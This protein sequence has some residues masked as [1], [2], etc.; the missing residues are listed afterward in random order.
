MAS[1]PRTVQEIQATATMDPEFAS[2]YSGEAEFPWDISALKKIVMDSLLVQQAKL[3]NTKP[4]QIIEREA[5]IKLDD[6]TDIRTIVCHQKDI[7]APSPVVILFHGGGHCIGF[8]EME[9]PFARDVALR[10][11]A[12]VICPAP[13]LAPEHE[14][15]GPVDDAFAITKCVAQELQRHNPSSG[16]FLPKE[17]S[18]QA[19]FIIGGTSSGANLATVVAHLARDS[20]LTPPLTGQYIPAGNFVNPFDVPEKYRPYYLSFEQNAKAPVIW[21]EFLQ[22]ARDALKADVNSPLWAPF[23]QHSPKDKHGE[24]IE[25]HVGL[26]PAYFQV[27]GLDPL[28]DDGLLYEKVLREECG[29]PTRLDLYPGLP[30]CWWDQYPQVS[31]TKRR[32]EDALNGIAWLLKVG[33]LHSVELEHT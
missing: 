10:F 25:G 24:V 4:A 17:A 13:R 32:Y 21:K 2:I 33:K 27:C 9:V 28:R 7:S 8:P 20:E 19:G 29:I 12:V 16:T 22:L 23:D 18:A 1:Y 15:P 26:P 11:N 3:E 5:F 14:F 30:H 6:D 31:T